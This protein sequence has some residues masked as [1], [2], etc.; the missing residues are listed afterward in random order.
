MLELKTLVKTYGGESFWQLNC[1]GASI[2]MG[3]PTLDQEK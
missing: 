3:L 2:R 1:N